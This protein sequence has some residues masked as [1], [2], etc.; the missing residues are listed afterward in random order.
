[1]ALTI[2]LLLLGAGAGVQAN[3]TPAP[4]V[5]INPE[6]SETSTNGCVVVPPLELAACLARF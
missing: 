2:L 1:V 4:P 3:A 6:A 5:T